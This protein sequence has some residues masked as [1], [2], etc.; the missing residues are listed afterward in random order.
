M[1]NRSYDIERAFCVLHLEPLFILVVPMVS[2]VQP[3]MFTK[4]RQKCCL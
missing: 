4:K 2:E 1:Q 3:S